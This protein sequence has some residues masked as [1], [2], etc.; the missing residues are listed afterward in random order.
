MHARESIN[1]WECMFYGVNSVRCLVPP[2]SQHYFP[3]TQLQHQPP[4]TSQ[5][6]VFFSHTTPALATSISTANRVNIA[7]HC[8]EGYI[9]ILISIVRE[10]FIS[11]FNSINA[12]SQQSR[13]LNSTSGH[14]DSD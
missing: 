5:P 13:I 14:L 7:V 4:A 6:T 2:A 3:L 11:L 1:Q 10:D 9:N 12:N 8:Y